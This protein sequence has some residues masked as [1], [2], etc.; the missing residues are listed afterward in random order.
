M[1]N[2]VALGCFARTGR[3]IV[4]ALRGPTGEPAVAARTEIA[5]VDDDLSPFVYHAAQD[6]PSSEAPVFVKRALL[7]V[8][9]AA[10]EHLAE[11]VSELRARGERVIG[12][13]IVMGD[14]PVASELERILA[15]HALVHA[16]EGELYRD[17]L[18]SAA[19]RLRI[20]VIGTP[21]HELFTRAS[22]SAGERAQNLAR[23]LA[24]LG[25]EVGPP[26]RQYEKQAAAAAWIALAA[27]GAGG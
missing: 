24:A 15:S 17:A 4:V 14:R 8:Q 5:L 19:E 11:V 25:R 7:V 13:G 20:P 16:A 12:A 10:R 21:R 3:A 6:L 23:R 2:A 18:S 27:A 9:R 26:W 22:A 1:S